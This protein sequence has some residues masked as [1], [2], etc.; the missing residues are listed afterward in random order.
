VEEAAGTVPR[1]S[2]DAYNL[3]DDF[4]YV[5]LASYHAMLGRLVSAAAPGARLVYWNM[6]VPRHRPESMAALLE[7]AVDEAKR[8]QRIDRAFFYQDLVVEVVS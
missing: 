7:P 2:I 4:E 1:G 5:D 3:S 6:L 8:L